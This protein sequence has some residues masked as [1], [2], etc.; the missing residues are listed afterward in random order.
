MRRVLF[1][2]LLL[3]VGLG[4]MAPGASA[5][6]TRQIPDGSVEHVDAL[7][8]QVEIQGDGTVRFTE[9]I[10]YDFGG[11]SR[12]GIYRD[13]VVR[14]P[15]DADNE[16]VYPFELVSVS[17]E[18]APDEVAE[19]VEGAAQR[20][21]IGD[22]DVLVEGIHTYTVV[23][24]LQGVLNGFADHDEL[25]WNVVGNTWTVPLENVTVEVRAPAAIQEVACFRGDFGSTAECATATAEGATASF[26]EPSIDASGAMT[27]VVGLPKG[28]VPEPVPVLE[29]IWKFE[30]AFDV[31]PFTVAATSVLGVLVL[32]GVGTLLWRVGRDRRAVGSVI[33]VGFAT[34]EERVQRVGFREDQHWP[35]EFAPPDGIRPGLIGTLVDEKVDPIDV[36]ATMIDL[37]VRGHLRVEEVEKHFAR[38]DYRLVRLPDRPGDDLEPFETLLLSKLFAGRGPTVLLSELKDEFATSYGKVVDAMYDEVVERRWFDRSPRATRSTWAVIGLGAVIAGVGLMIA[39]ARFTHLALLSVPFVAGGIV[40]LVGSRKMPART[41][42]GHGLLRRCRGF[43]TFIQESEKERAR[44]AAQQNLFSEYLPYAMVFGAVEKWANA[45]TDLNGNLPAAVTGWYVGTHVFTPHAFSEA[46]TGFAVSTATTL[47]STPGGSGGSG[48]GG[49]GFSGGGGGGGGGGS[50]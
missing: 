35:V 36:S 10:R 48:F 12:H 40:L 46:V 13:I 3:L 19:L 34:G 7:D 31:N 17:S 23:Y 47:Q 26:A 41:S 24:E 5:S 2:V 42:L 50:W 37:A 15:F 32:G 16:R 11:L 43:E 27:I 28:A 33:D 30:K 22:P 39:A 8:V 14:Q 4:V 49:G 9:T 20:L 29:E 45:F 21:R 6:M 18:T 38:D 25:Y 44:F 1:P